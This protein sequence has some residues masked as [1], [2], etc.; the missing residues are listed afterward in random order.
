MA[1][2]VR[3]ALSSTSTLLQIEWSKE[4]RLNLAKTDKVGILIQRQSMI[5]RRQI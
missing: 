5:Q 3:R 4:N 2:E 1:H